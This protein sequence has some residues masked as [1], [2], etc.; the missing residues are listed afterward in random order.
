MGFENKLK[1]MGQKYNGDPLHF[2]GKGDISH[3]L[4]HFSNLDGKFNLMT[5]L[6][7]TRVFANNMYGGGMNTI[8]SVG[9]R[10]TKNSLSLKHLNQVIPAGKGDKINPLDRSW[11]YY[12]KWVSTTGVNEAF[13]RQELRA[14]PVFQG[15][16]KDVAHNFIEEV[17]TQ[18]KKSKNDVTKKTM[19]EVAKKYGISQSFLE[20]SGFFM[21]TSERYLRRSAFLAHYLKGQDSFNAHRGTFGRDDK[22]LIDYAI[23]GVTGTQYLYHNAYRNP[24][25]STNMGRVFSRFRLWML[26]SLKFRKDIVKHAANYNFEQGTPEMKRFERLMIADAFMVGLGTMFPY[27]LFDST[28]PP[29][30]DYL[31]DFSALM[32]GNDTERER[33][34][35]GTLPAPFNALQIVSPPSG[36]LLLQPLGA[37][38]KDDW[39]RFA[40]RDIWTWFPWGRLIHTGVKTVNN[41][42]GVVDYTTGLPLF[43]LNQLRQDAKGEEPES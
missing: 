4:A 26:N 1:K 34:F 31:Q 5:L 17:I 29:P 28:V 16:Y 41:P 10:H 33:A 25:T 15:K 3:R 11:E 36:R 21:K 35:F 8:I 12:D 24:F 22:V 39:G 27:S 42:L 9:L 13:M 32:Y 38:L 40:E 20:K 43:R 23:K 14:N 30:Y 6:M 19:L 37:L 18:R 2:I 7:N